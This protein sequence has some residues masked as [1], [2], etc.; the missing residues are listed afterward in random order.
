MGAEDFTELRV[1]RLTNAD[2]TEISELLSNL[3][4]DDSKSAN[5]Q[6]PFASNPFFSRFASRFGGG[7]PG[8]G[9]GGPPGSSSTTGGSGNQNQRVKKR[10]R[11][12][13][14]ADQRTA[15]IIVSATRDLMEQIEGVV[16]ELDANP[17]GRTTV[18]VYRLEN[19]DPQEA[20]P[21]LQDIFQKNNTTQNNRNTANQNSPLLNR[22]ST[23]N[24]QNNSGSRSTT[25]STSR[26]GAGGSLPSFNQ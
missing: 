21:V 20:L 23:Q 1:F 8:G 6:S 4:P 24:Q 18:K 9:A 14:V 17:K 12:I 13:T 19:A 10:N 11:V 15:S 3:F 7:P 5:S 26:G 25:G 16:T 22:S 2:P